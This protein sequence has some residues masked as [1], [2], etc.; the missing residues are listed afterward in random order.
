MIELTVSADVRDKLLTTDGLSADQPI[1]DDLLEISEIESPGPDPAENDA[2]DTLK[3]FLRDIRSYRLLTPEEEVALARCIEHGDPAAKERMIASNLRLVVSIAK[4]Y[5]GQGVPLPDLIQEGSIG[6]HRAVERFDWRR[7]CRFSTYA[8]WWIRHACQRAVLTQSRTIYV[9]THIGMRRRRVQRAAVALEGEL[10]REPTLVELVEATDLPQ[11]QVEDALGAADAPVSLNQV[12]G[13][14]ELAEQVPDPNGWD[15]VSDMVDVLRRQQ[16][17]RAL[18]TL[19]DRERRVIELRYGFEGD[20]ENAAKTG[21][22]L[23]MTRHRVQAYEMRALTR[24][25]HILRNSTDAQGA[26]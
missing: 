5:V 1:D 13:S 9:P 18:A 6:L 21:R 24:L 22:L 17:R 10:G 25:F 3:L 15:P 23:G 16:I 7:G 14:R 11:E 20:G 2:L 4:Y 12:V 26:R 8:S 19:P